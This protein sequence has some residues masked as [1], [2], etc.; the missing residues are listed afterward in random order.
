MNNTPNTKQNSPA[1]PADEWQELLQTPDVMSSSDSPSSRDITT[2]ADYP[3]EIDSSSMSSSSSKVNITW[4]TPEPEEIDGSGDSLH[5][6]VSTTFETEVYEDTAAKAWRVRLLKAEGKTI[7]RLYKKGFR[8]ADIETPDNEADAIIAVASMNA[9]RTNGAGAWHTLGAS[10]SHETYHRTQWMDASNFYWDEMQIQATVEG[11]SYSSE[12]LEAGEA[13]TLI[14]ARVNQ[15]RDNFNALAHTY[16]ALLPDK[17]GNFESRGFRVGQSVLNQAVARIQQQAKSKNWTSVPMDISPVDDFS[18]PCHLPPVDVIY[19]T[20][21][22]VPM[23]AP[24]SLP[25]KDT[26][27]HIQMYL[28]NPQDMRDQSLIVS[29]LNNGTET[30]R[31]LDRFTPDLIRY[32]FFDIILT[33]KQGEELVCSLARANVTF[34]GKL[35]Y[36]D[37]QPGFSWNVSVPLHDLISEQCP[38]G[39]PAGEYTLSVI[40]HNKYGED[41]IKGSL[42][43]AENVLI[44]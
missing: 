41:C 23:N 38:E 8:D 10:R 4:I 43:V 28:V 39:L 6:P 18:K 31:L 20:S 1:S 35:E 26:T 27:Q 11:V 21:R 13:T 42:Q 40:Y 30:T 33:N 36:Q 2:P 19:G 15:I 9:Y 14:N 5:F 44:E 25:E 29:F 16:I 37:I 24:L 22:S 7:I 12:F 32:V 3:W 34:Q 17:P